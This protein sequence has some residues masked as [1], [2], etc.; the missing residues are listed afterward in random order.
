[1]KRDLSFEQAYSELESIVK[2]IEDESTPLEKL[3]ELYEKG[4]ELSSYCRD[5]LEKTEKKLK[6]LQ[7]NK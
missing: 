3:L 5:I 6:V 7:D 2:E 1:M 4:S